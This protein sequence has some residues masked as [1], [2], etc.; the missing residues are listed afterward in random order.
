[1]Y[2]IGARMAWVAVVFVVAALGCR[3][4]QPNLKPLPEPEAFNPP[5]KEARFETAY[6][7][8]AGFPSDDPLKKL[9]DGEG[10][11]VMPARMT[12]PAGMTGPARQ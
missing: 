9:R 12:G 4:P 10:Q 5:P 1:M 2:R 7:P 6:F 11:T 3:T 8:K